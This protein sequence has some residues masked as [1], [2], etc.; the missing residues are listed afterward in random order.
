[1]NLKTLFLS[2]PFISL[3]QDSVNGGEVYLGVVISGF[4]G[5]SLININ[6]SAVFCWSLVGGYYVRFNLRRGALAASS[7]LSSWVGSSVGSL[8]S[9][10]S[11]GFSSSSCRYSFTVVVLKSVGPLG[12]CTLYVSPSIP[13]NLNGPVHL[14][15]CLVLPSCYTS[16]SK[17]RGRSWIVVTDRP[18]RWFSAS[19]TCFLALILAISS[20]A[21][22]MAAARYII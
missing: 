10:S 6:I 12:N 16:T 13:S 14:L 1:M 21:F 22:F 17:L 18:F 11:L 4:V 19:L 5:V 9:S 3:C 7:L 8:I 2:K 15:L 20:I